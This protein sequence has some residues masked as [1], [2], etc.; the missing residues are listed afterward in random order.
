MLKNEETAESFVLSGDEGDV[1]VI[2]ADCIV[3]G[4]GAAGLSAVNRLTDFG[5]KTVLLTEDR[6]AGTSRNAGSDKQTYYK[7][8]LGGEACDSV[9]QMA[10]DLFACGKTDGDTALSEAALS[11]K[12]FLYL[13]E[14]GVGFPKNRFGEYIGYKTDHDPYA[15][16]SS[17]GPLTSKDMTEA[18]EKRVNS[19]SAI[20]RED[21][22]AVKLLKDEKGVFGVLALNRKTGAFEA[23]TAPAVILAVGGPAG[24]YEDSVYPESQFGASG[25]A[26]EAGA[27]LQNASIW[28]YG[29]ASV[30]PRWNVSGSYM[31]VLPCFISVGE[32]GTEREFLLDYYKDPYEAL[33]TV[34]L[35]GYQWPFDERKAETGSSRIDLLVYEERV[36]KHRRVYLDYSRN[37][38]GL[39]CIDFSRLSEEAR[40][41]LQKTGAAFGTPIERLLA[42]NRPAVD[43]YSDKGVD[44]RKERLEIAVCAQHHNGGI[45]VD[46]WWRSS[47]PGLFAVGECAG[48]HGLTR[49]GGSALNAGQVGAYRAAEYIAEKLAGSG[50]ISERRKGSIADAADDEMRFLRRTR[51]NPDNVSALM[52]L[53]QHEM[54]AA[55]AAV[56]DKRG[57]RDLKGKVCELLKHF[58]ERVGIPAEDTA[59]VYRLKSLLFTQ[60]AVLS[61]MEEDDKD[62]GRILEVSLKAG[63][64]ALRKRPVRP[65]PSSDVSFETVW[66]EYRKNKNVY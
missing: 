56:R 9:R 43:L 17:A 64:M 29:L 45:A 55:A 15:R 54:T 35:K 30:Q 61:S 60:W 2:L 8:A 32:D 37:P 53:F 62:P 31:Q 16:A 23:F 19:S 63:D 59:S 3:V 10:E 66:A 34:F 20:I 38:F 33:S 24:I 28:Q 14:L 13:S 12:C 44:L 18:L 58:E 47:V 49:P 65:I 25:L 5:M 48:T 57:I 11:A 7:L 52:S 36:M 39:T 21:H 40:D 51:N 4:S 6:Y 42:M 26:I 41:Y 22:L 1:S 46:S 27:A 50:Y